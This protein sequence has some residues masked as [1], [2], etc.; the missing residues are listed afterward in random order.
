MSTLAQAICV[1]TSARFLRR[2]LGERVETCYRVETS[3]SDGYRPLKVSSGCDCIVEDDG[4]S[5][6][7][8]HSRE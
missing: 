5:S 6:R 3:Q 2:L 7:H 4:E 8:D 1:T